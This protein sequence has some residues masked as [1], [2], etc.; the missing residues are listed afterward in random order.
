MPLAPDGAEMRR[1]TPHFYL[2]FAG[3]ILS[4]PTAILTIWAYYD[5]RPISSEAAFALA[6]ATAAVLYVTWFWGIYLLVSG[7]VPRPMP[8][9]AAHAAVGSVI[10]LLYTAGLGLQIPTLGAQP[11]GTVQVYI[12]AGAMIILGAQ[13]TAARLIFGG[14]GVAW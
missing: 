14:R 5:E 13:I 7:H 2:A 11:L 10:P 1:H 12:N 9:L 8:F 6:A 3:L 4:V